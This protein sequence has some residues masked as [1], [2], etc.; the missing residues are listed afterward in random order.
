MPDKFSENTSTQKKISRSGWLW[1]LIIMVMIGVL[2]LIMLPAGIDYGI[3]RFLKDQGADQV[4]LEDVDFNPF[5]GRLSL[6]NLSIISDAQNVLLIPQVT[7]D[8]AWRPFIS[9]RIV[10]KRLNVSDLQLTVEELKDGRWQIGG[11]KLPDTDETDGPS[12]WAFGLDQVSIKNSHIKFI[13]S[14]LSSD[15]KIEQA[16]ISKLNSWIP[17]ES[18]RLEFTGRLDDTRMQLRLDTSLFGSERR[19]AGR[20]K[21][22]GLNLSPLGRLL[23]PQRK[24]LQGRLDVDLTV[25][26]HQNAGGGF[27]HHQKGPIKLY[28]IQS[29]IADIKLATENLAWDGTIEVDTLE[30]GETL[31]IAADGRLNGSTLGL[32]IENENLKVQQDDFSW[33]GKFDYTADK[34]GRKIT[35]DSQIRLADLK[36]TLP[37]INVVEKALSWQGVFEFSSNP[38][39]VGRKIIADGGL[40][41]SALSLNIEKEGLGIQQDNYSWT[42]KFDYAAG[43][44]GQK[45]TADGQLRMADLKVASPQFKLSEEMLTWQGPL[46]FSTNASPENRRIIADGALNGSH[47]QVNLLTRKFKS[48]HHGFSWKGRL[49]SGET[50]DFSSLNAEAD[51]VINEIQ[52]LNSETNQHLLDAKRLDLQAVKFESLD[53]VSISSIALSGLA[54]LAGPEADQSSSVNPPPVRIQE[55]KFHDVRLLQQNN[56]A[57]DAIRLN[58][59]RAFVHRDGEGKLPAVDKWKV[60]QGDAF[61]ADQ[62]KRTSG[63]GVKQKSDLFGFRIGQIEITGDS[64]LQFRDES[65]NPNFSKDL[66]ILEARLS[67]LDSNRPQ[68]SSSVKLLISDKE[69]ARLSLDGTI[70]PFAEQ[71]SLDWNGKIEALELPPL[72]PYVNR[73]TGYSF[74]NGELQADIPLKINQ[75]KLNGAIALML[76]NPKVK[77]E[78][79][80]H[81]QKGKIGLGMSLDS[82]LKLMRDE[83]NDVKLKIPIRGDISDPKF[84]VSDAINKV[85]VKTLQKSAISY[86]KYML[87][88][89]GI[90]ISVAQLAYEQVTKI[91]LNPILF[92]PGSDD[93]DE[94]AIDYLQR[95]A[96]IMKEYP[97]VRV[98]VCGVATESD[99]AAMRANASIEDAALLELAKNRTKRIEDQLVKSHDIAAD[100][101]VACR[102]EI[103]RNAESKPRAGL[104]L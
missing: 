75:N 55:I 78:G 76:Y 77:A 97:A 59:A 24:A 91:R 27:S 25:K 49:D 86:L 73:S 2:S 29:Q 79:Q 45:I 84:S 7:L 18:A 14:P 81:E 95:V 28:Q 63:S 62:K 17:G 34:T 92:A 53:Q 32:D 83:N 67:D 15:L 36:A 64:E 10:L 43:N 100:R 48:E 72:S 38:E 4:T 98:S 68:Q 3:V 13:S 70:Q 37:R 69:N 12:A 40:N 74:T 80:P 41:G 82:A 19:A 96:A 46:E 31:K 85:L 99:R 11:I 39:T 61:S 21:I 35:T 57:I 87:G 58:A 51:L 30:S 94:T 9:K 33:K 26:M 6:K 44:N 60:I 20:I 5:T 90:G 65:V 16:T 56:L 22:E 23:Q 54:L 66:R 52:I 102:P 103:D 1:I 42:G 88:P 101:I 93:L 71:L 89:Y 104:E 8:I 47:L 50:K